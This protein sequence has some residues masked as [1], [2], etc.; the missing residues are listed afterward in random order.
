MG[1][2]NRM[3]LPQYVHQ[4]SWLRASQLSKG[5]LYAVVTPNPRVGTFD[6]E[7]VDTMGNRYVRLSGYRTAALPGGFDAESLKSL[8]TILQGE[9]V[10]A[11]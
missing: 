2:H 9:A 4:V 11:P 8:Q 1:A 6:A 7:V 10:T 3:G 5:H